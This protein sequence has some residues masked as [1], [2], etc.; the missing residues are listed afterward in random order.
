MDMQGWASK[1]AIHT[2]WAGSRLYGTARPDSDWDLRGVCRMPPE[3]LLGLM[4]FD[5]YQKHNDEED[6]CIYGRTKFFALALDANPNILDIL[7]APPETWLAPKPEWRQVYEARH[8]FLSQKLR[9]TFSGYAVSQ[10]KRLQRHYQWLTHPPDHA[11]TLEQFS[12][13]LESNERGGQKKI[14]PHLDA[15]NRYDQAV[16]HWKQY[17]TWLREHNPARAEL[18]RKY[19]YDT[20]HASHLVRLLL[21]VER[22]LRGGDYNPQLAEDTLGTVLGVLQGRWAYEQLVAWAEAA[23]RRVRSMDSVLPQR[24]ARQGAEALLMSLNRQSLGG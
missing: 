17:Q 3:A 15:Q 14:F 22:V 21:Q 7:C 24:P 6:T 12:G 5:Q 18:E 13:R 20:K 2:I 1:H 11:P 9:H 23:D 10:L 4:R 16:K 8:L 19:G